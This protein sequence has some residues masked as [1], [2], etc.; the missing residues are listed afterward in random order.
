MY[1][2]PP[3]PPTNPTR[4]RR[5]DFTAALIRRRRAAVALL[6]TLSVAVALLAVVSFVKLLP[7]RGDASHTAAALRTVGALDRALQ[8]GSDAVE[9]RTRLPKEARAA[10]E[11]VL[12]FAREAAAVEPDDPDEARAARTF[13]EELDKAAPNL[14]EAMNFIAQADPALETGARQRADVGMKLV[15]AAAREYES[16]LARQLDEQMGAARWWLAVCLGLVLLTGVMMAVTV[17]TWAYA[18]Y[19][20][21]QRARALGGAAVGEEALEAAKRLSLAI[22]NG[23]LAVVEWSADFI[24][25]RWSG[26]AAEMFG[27]SAEEV[28]GKPWDRLKGHIHPDDAERVRREIAPLLDGRAA[29]VVIRHRNLRKDGTVLHC[30]WYNSALQDGAGKP[31]AFL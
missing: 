8:R 24:C 18:D 23:P 11:D 15:S 19:A 13:K 10:W 12:R 14:T 7:V 21:R 27:R 3:P 6:L 17:L 28:I 1:S 9:N 29:C 16:T 25:T 4:R 26:R 2:L 20:D 31:R 5:P 22:D 30:V